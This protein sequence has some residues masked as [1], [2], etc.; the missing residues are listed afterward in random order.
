MADFPTQLDK[1]ATLIGFLGGFWRDTYQGQDL[2]AEFLHARGQLA[3]QTFARL[4]EAIDCR[5]R[6]SIPVFKYKNWVPLVLDST[7]VKSFPNTYGENTYY[8]D[9]S[10][11][12]VR[13]ASLPFVYPIDYSI[14]DC[15]LI[16]NRVTDTSV[17]LVKGIDFHIDN[18]NHLI[19]FKKNPFLRDDLQKETA[20]DGTESITLWMFRPSIDDEYIYNHFGYVVKLWGKSSQSYKDLVNHVYDS[21]VLGTS[22]GRTVD[23]IC[24]ITGIPV[25]KGNET[26]IEVYK[27]SRSQ[28][29]LTDKNAYRVSD[30]ATV[31][32]APGDELKVDQAICDSLEIF[33]FNRGEYPESITGLSLNPGL[34]PGNYLNDLGFLNSDSATE[35]TYDDNGVIDIRFPIGGH[36]FDVEA[37]WEEVHSRGVASGTTLANLLDTRTNKEGD[38]VESNLPSSINPFGFLAANVLRNS[39]FVVSI[40]TQAIMPNGVGLDKLGYI[41]RLIHPHTAMILLITMPFIEE[42]AII[43]YEETISNMEVADTLT[44]DLQYTSVTDVISNRLVS[45]YCI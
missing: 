26:V 36:P 24:A 3:K 14:S 17:S 34:L 5:G 42:D 28:L 20:S 33:E 16:A 40:K 15:L 9:G 10:A 30:L 45:G 8:G 7:T 22:F 37:F 21:I 25:A 27:D 43:D 19:S 13:S 11:Y 1:K 35:I 44:E 18:E 29:V 23:A 31:T 41:Q 39:A 2:L 38:P 4:Q 6:F 32:V 12:G